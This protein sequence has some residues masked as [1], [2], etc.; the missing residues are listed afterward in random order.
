[1]SQPDS[2]TKLSEW[3]PWLETLSPREIVLGLDRV[4]TM[5]ERLDLQRPKTVIHVGGTNGKGSCAAMLAAMLQKGGIST[6]CYTSPHIHVYNERIRVDGITASDQE[7][8]RA[9]ELVESMRADLPLTFFEFGTLAALLVFDAA[10]VDAWV[11]EVG[12]GGRLDA[13]NAV[14]PDA[15]LITNVSLDHCAW[16]GDNVESIAAEKAGIMR[17]GRPVIFGNTNVPD[18]IRT[19]A[20]TVG[21]NLCIAGQ[22]FAYEKDPVDPE[23]WSWRGARIELKGLLTPSLAGEVQLENA[24]AVLATIEAMEFDELLTTSKVNGVLPYMALEGRFQVVQRRC[25]WVLDVAHNPAAAAA[26]V[27]RLADLQVAG[28][29]TAIIGLLKDKNVQG[30]VEPLSEFVDR[31]IAVTVTGSRAAPAEQTGQEIADLTGKPC[32][33]ADTIEG[34][35]ESAAA[36]A[37][38][39]DGVIVTGSFYLVGPAIDWLSRERKS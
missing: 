5:L 1:M 16:L 14:D 15:S 33:I 38:A 25:R 28:R 13:V 39:N 36:E 3:L 19:S 23:Y 34:A 37:C 35:M 7:I 6:G 17:A 2:F 8:L 10:G 11:L 30:V 21:A 9:L 24:A 20:V 4:H 27:D 18:A 29:V 31:W 12:L 32:L 22:D 26:L